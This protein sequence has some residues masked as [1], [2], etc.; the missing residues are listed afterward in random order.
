VRN[1]LRWIV[2]E[3]MEDLGARDEDTE[4]DKKGARCCHWEGQLVFVDVQGKEELDADSI[5]DGALDEEV[6]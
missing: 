5:D 6:A 3:V 2:D 1:E 4:T